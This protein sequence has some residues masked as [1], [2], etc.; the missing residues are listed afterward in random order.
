MITTTG[1]ATVT[2]ATPALTADVFADHATDPAATDPAATDP[3]ATDAAVGRRG[4]GDAWDVAQVLAR[5]EALPV[6]S[7]WPAQR[8]RSTDRAAAGILSGLQSYPGEGWAQ[9]WAA[10]G[11]EQAPDPL[12]T[13][14]VLTGA[15]P[16]RAPGRLATKQ[17]W[18]GLLLTQ[19]VLPGYGFLTALHVAPPWYDEARAVLAPAMFTRLAARADELG[20]TARTRADA[21]LV[22]TKL[23][24]H[25][26]LTPDRLGVAEFDA[27]HTGEHA[28][29]GNSPPGSVAAWDLLRCDEACQ[30]IPAE[31]GYREHHRVGAQPTAVMVDRYQLRRAAVR[32]VL[33]RYLDERRPGMDFPSFRN[34][35]GHLVG[36]FWKDIE[37]HHPDVGSLH[38]PEPVAAA[39]KQRLRST[40]RAGVPTRPRRDFLQ[41]LMAVRAFYLDIQEWAVSD[42]SWAEHAVPCPIR[43]AEIRGLSKQRRATIAGV[44]QRIRERL[45]RLPALVDTAA[46]YHRDRAALLT[47]TRAADS[48]Q[49]FT[50]DGHHYRRVLLARPGTEDQHSPSAR[51]VEL[52]TGQIHDLQAEEDD[53]FWS[54]AIVE[55]LRHTGLRLEELL[56]LTH[57]ALVHY[58]LNDTGEI[59]P[60]LQIVPSKADQERLLLVSPEL[61]NVLA[62]IINRLRSIGSGTIPIIPRWDRHERIWAPALPYLFQR[63]SG[64]RN[65][66]VSVTSVQN[67]LNRTLARAGLRDA[68]DEL[69]IFTPHDFRRIFATEAVSGGLPVH[70][71]AHLLGHA[72]ITSTEAYVAV[73]QDQLIVTYRAYLDS[74]RA[75]RPQAEYR[76]PTDDE[77]REFQQHFALRKL[78]LGTCA[79]PFQTPCR[80]EH[81]CIR[82]PMLRVDPRQRDRLADITRNL[83]ERIADAQ[84]NGWHGEIEGLR[85][86]LRAAETKLVDLDRQSRNTATNLGIPPLAP[87]S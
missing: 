8:Q 60:L 66:V 31:L 44:H 18:M 26:G 40:R 52:A 61:A 9:R 85:I 84:H 80:H 68:N 34:M 5:I 42:P 59:V 32:D 49:G 24:L 2:T 17:G 36:A 19:T 25:T 13:L 14:R 43:R 20:M 39:W 27:L 15:A 75:E 3:A 83:R 29:I 7:G 4:L 79:R 58:R 48:D 38:L 78:E 74:R 57:L 51:V 11:V 50:H 45:P 77:W 23:V 46:R 12:G 87:R 21:L 47:A 62:T 41:H 33:V 30:G 70:I 82:C 64:H 71:T 81:A 16:G 72:R 22:I 6:R 73:F 69:M 28:R 76:Q 53:A 56:E 86:S 35:V 54:W 63:R 37:T 1:T 10:A 67:M 65:R 55:V